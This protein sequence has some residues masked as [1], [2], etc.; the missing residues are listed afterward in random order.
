MT[1]LVAGAAGFLGSHLVQVLLNS[2]RSVIGLDNFVTGQPENIESFANNASWKFIEHDVREP[3]DLSE[4]TSGIFNLASPASPVHYQQDPIATLTTNVIGSLNLL[5]L[6]KKLQVPILQ[7]STSEVYGDPEEH[8]QRETYVGRVNPIGPRA[9]YDE[10]KRAAET[11]FFDFHRKYGVQIKVARLFNSYGPRMSPTDGRVISSMIVKCL[12]EEPIIIFG[13][14]SQTRSFTY[15]TDTVDGLARL[16]KVNQPIPAPV[17]LGNTQESTVL[18]LA[19]LIRKL[20]Q[21]D[22]EIVFKD[23]RDDDP[24]QR[25]PDITVAQEL[26]GWTPRVNLDQGLIETIRYFRND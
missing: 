1:Y 2:G 21:S 25:K 14:G 12:A 3:I 18:E 26:L 16:M 11:L 8:P 22:S 4:V 15:F 24:T 13:D 6:A 17:N 9:C 23:P 20:T 5:N 10:G 7:A 19:Y